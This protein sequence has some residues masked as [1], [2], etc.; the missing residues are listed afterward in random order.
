M[1]EADV[2]ANQKGGQFDTNAGNADNSA[3]SD[4]GP[5]VTDI[6]PIGTPAH[7]QPD[8][9]PLGADANPLETPDAPKVD[10]KLSTL[11][12][13]PKNHDP[14]SGDV[15][16]G[17]LP[18]DEGSV[19]VDESGVPADDSEAREGWRDRDQQTNPE[20]RVDTDESE[21]PVDGSGDS[22]DTNA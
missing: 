2:G 13:Q 18:S 6:T 12:E 15:V 7:D 16:D 10:P 21:E 14:I 1:P 4:T 19:T 9:R 20:D 22:T 3:P 17:G 11:D 8:L 5:Q